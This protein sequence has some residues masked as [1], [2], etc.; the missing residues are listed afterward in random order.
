MRPGEYH[1]RIEKFLRR[2]FT[3]PPLMLKTRIRYHA[4]DGRIRAPF[5]FERMPLRHSVPCFGYAFEVDGKRTAYCTDTGLCANLK[6]LAKDA[7]LLITECAMAPED[8]GENIF[9]S[10]RA[11][12]PL[13]RPAQREETRA[14]TF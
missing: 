4:V 10:R 7:D 12:P 2:P 8:T 1:K 11:P 3:S 9:I 6:R 14:Y 13:S 5:T